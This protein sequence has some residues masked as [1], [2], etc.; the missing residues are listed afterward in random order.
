MKQP[1]R[2]T[3]W[4]T[5]LLIATSLVALPREGAVAAPIHDE[6]PPIVDE[7]DPDVPGTEAAVAVQSMRPL[8]LG[9]LVLVRLGPIPAFIVLP[10]VPY[11][12]HGQ[13]GLARGHRR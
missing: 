3:V 11:S 10:K 9:R 4:L 1:G 12:S 6:I 2:W 5:A 13:T 8:I 7:G